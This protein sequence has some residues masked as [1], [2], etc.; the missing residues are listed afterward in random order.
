[1]HELLENV[2]AIFEEAFEKF[3]PEEERVIKLIF[4][5]DG[6]KYTYAQIEEMLNIPR[7][8]I[9]SVKQRA[10]RKLRKPLPRSRIEKHF[11][12]IF[13]LD[14]DNFYFSLTKTVFGF[15]MLAPEIQEARGGIVSADTDFFLF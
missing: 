1:M 3:S 11:L 8:K 13:R 6:I 5:Y 10:L 2:K 15:T 12:E 7:N 14:E 4:R 9:G